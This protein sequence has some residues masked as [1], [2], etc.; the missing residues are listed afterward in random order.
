MIY[1][2]QLRST[3]V[4]LN[5]VWLRLFQLQVIYWSFSCGRA[6]DDVCQVITN[7]VNVTIV[8]CSMNK[9]TYRRIA[10][11]AVT[12]AT[13]LVEPL[14]AF[15]EQETDRSIALSSIVTTSSQRKLRYF[16]DVFSGDDRTKYQR[17]FAKSRTPTPNVV[18]IDAADE[19]A[20][21]SKSAKVIFGTLKTDQ[22]IQAKADS[23]YWM[24]A[25]LST[26]PST[27]T[28]YMIERASIEGNTIRLTY[29][30]PKAELVTAD[31]RHYF[32]WI[33]LGQLKPAAYKVELYDSDKKAVTLSRLIEVKQEKPR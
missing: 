31:V 12:L 3:L 27:P 30:K 13:V 28:A 18:L 23:N 10:V 24:V 4:T 32:Y 11:L 6:F 29:Y 33:P 20:A 2:V 7:C 22:V 14:V 9:H 19:G 5:A 25:F 17:E 8:A 15:A 16:N 1:C 26:G 21:I